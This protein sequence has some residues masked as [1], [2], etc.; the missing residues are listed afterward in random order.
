MAVSRGT[1]HPTAPASLSSCGTRKWLSNN[2][3]ILDGL[4]VIGTS[5]HCTYL[6]L[7]HLVDEAHALLAYGVGLGHPHVLEVDDGGVGGV[8]TDLVDLLCPDYTGSV[9][10]DDDERLVLVRLAAFARVGQKA[11]PIGLQAAGN[12]H[13]LPV[14][15]PVVAPFHRLATNT[16]WFGP[17]L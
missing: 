6:E 12:P 2:I 9:H 15:D 3:I 8:H 1:R 5:C 11:H 10:G 7:Q 14:D 17:C 13:L 16:G 4:V